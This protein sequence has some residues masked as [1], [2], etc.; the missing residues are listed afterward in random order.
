[1]S[2]FVDTF[3]FTSISITLVIHLWCKK[4]TKPI[5]NASIL[6]PK[7]KEEVKSDN[8]LDIDECG[9]CTKLVKTVKP[10]DKHIIICY[11]IESWPSAVEKAYPVSAF[12][13]AID[14]TKKTYKDSTSSQKPIS[15]KITLCDQKESFHGC[16]DII[17]YPDNC[18]FTLRADQFDD[19][20]ANLYSNSLSKYDKISL[21]WK[22]LI[23]ICKHNSRDN[24]CGTMGPKIIE[25]LQTE[26]AHRNINESEIAVRGSSHIGGHEFAGTLILYPEMDWYGHIKEETIPKLLD[27]IISGS[28]LMACFRGNP[29]LDW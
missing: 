29:L 4:G 28:R 26:L 23:L 22:K 5:N 12:V 24:R 10:Y 14:S 13:S 20:A 17:M 16:I 2:T 15:V 11:N 9:R 6:V 18:M 3:Y 25:K 7:L 19:F 1:M 21:P 27:N 8:E